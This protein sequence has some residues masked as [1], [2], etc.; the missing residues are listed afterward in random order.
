MDESAT[1]INTARD[2]DA[3][4]VWTAAGFTVGLLVLRLLAIGRFGLYFD[5]AYYWLWSTQLQGSYY[6]HPPM[7]AVFI[8][9]GT[10]LFGETEFGVRFAGTISMAISA[11]LVYAISIRLWPSRRI[12]AWAVLLFNA[13][14]IMTLSVFVVPDEPMLMFWLAA[15]YGMAAIAKGGD[16]RWWVFIG[17]MLGAAAASK[18]TTLFLG[19]AIPLWLI[20]VPALRRWLRSPWTYLGV[21][22]ALIVLIPTLVW[23]V[24]N[25]WAT[26]ATQ[27]N[28]ETFDR[29][30]PEGFLRY[31]VLYPIMVT[32]SVLILG[33]AGYVVLLCDRWRLDPGRALLVLTPIPLTVYLAYYSFSARIGEHW[34]SPVVVMLALFGGV[35]VQASGRGCKRAAIVWSKRTA[36]PIGMAVV[37]AFYLPAIVAPV[38]TVPRDVDLT[39]RYRGW[40]DYAA[41]VEALRIARGAAYLLGRHYSDPGYFRFYAGVDTP[42][43][44]LGEIDR[45]AYLGD[46]AGRV[47]PELTA[48]TGLYIGRRSVEV[49]V[50]FLAEYFQTVIPLG[51][52]ARRMRDDL[53][54]STQA[55]LVSDP[56]A[57]V[58]PLFGVGP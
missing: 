58:M 17:L 22:A 55:F 57:A 46:D 44:Q 23:N 25:D 5:E 41:S 30:R 24:Q 29:L 12:A 34:F 11:F 4:L 50:A 16:G 3:L 47:A 14:T 45:W 49:E 52:V 32:P 42:A 21:G 13:T 20:L 37:V 6:D 8:R 10:L 40:P 43:Y 51:P 53:T 35:A 39:A 33:I 28:R 54:T 48:A 36:V 26:L 38:V 31:L 19:A 56:K 1:S 7:V 18:A 2:T 15:V 9:V 27:Y